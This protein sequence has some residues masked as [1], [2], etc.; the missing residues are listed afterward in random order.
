MMDCEL[1]KIVDAMTILDEEL[2]GLWRTLRYVKDKT[3][4]EVKPDD[5]YG[6]PGIIRAIENMA[7][8]YYMAYH[9]IL[10]NVQNLLTEV[11][12]K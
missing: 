9:D 7:D 2:E 11:E 6:L 4:F 3:G 12:N 8:N 10:E 1:R 5:K